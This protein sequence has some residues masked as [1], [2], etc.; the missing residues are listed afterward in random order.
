MTGYL[1]RRLAGVAFNLVVLSVLVFM[2]M[3]VLPGDPAEVIGGIGAS[4]EEVNA[5]REKLGLTKPLYFQ[6]IRWVGNLVRG[7]L[8]R[9]LITGERIA[10]MI[11]FR[12]LNTLKLAFAGIVFASLIGIT[13]GVVSAIK[14][15]TVMDY[16][17]T[18][19]AVLGI[20]MPIFW[21]GLLLIVLFAVKLEWLPAGGTGGIEYLVLPAVTIGLNSTAIIARMTRSSMLDVLRKDYVRTALAKG[22][23]QRRVIFLHALRNASVP[24]V[25]TVGL[26]FGMLMGGAVLTESVFDWAGIG[27]LL[28]DAV[29]KRDFPLV[30]VLLLIF[31]ALFA[32]T[33]LLV[34]LCYCII[35]P[36]IRYT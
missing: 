29:F 5:I 18:I 21:I 7:D 32:I 3:H 1:V 26:Q 34:D 19:F 4:P 23:S 14:H 12:V 16:M 10:D 13:L 11:G 27:R 36:R 30:Q 2:L 24:I 28:V 20:S 15:N 35:D 6:Y 8:G 9:S 22:L 17:A 25:T 31:G 33:N